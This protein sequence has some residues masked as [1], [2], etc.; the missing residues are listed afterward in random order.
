MAYLATRPEIS[1][2]ALSSNTLNDA[3]E[4][5]SEPNDQAAVNALWSAVNYFKLGAN[6]SYSALP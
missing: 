1:N 3:L 6:C 4:S 5:L 2:L